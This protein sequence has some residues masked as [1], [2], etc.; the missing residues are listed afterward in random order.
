MHMS[1]ICMWRP[2]EGDRSL[3][4]EL[5]AEVNLPMWLLGSD[6]RYSAGAACALTH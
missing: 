3:E 5:Q 6:L 4:L 1:A 2:E